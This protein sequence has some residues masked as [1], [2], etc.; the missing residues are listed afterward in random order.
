[1]KHYI[2]ILT[3]L[4]LF[5]C[6]SDDN[7]TNIENDDLLGTWKVFELL[8][9]QGD[10]S[11]T[12]QSVTYN[13]TIKFLSNGIVE[14]SGSL[15]FMGTENNPSSGT[16]ELDSESE[17]IEGTIKSSDC[18][19]SSPSSIVFYKIESS[20]LILRYNCNEGCAEKFVKIE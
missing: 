11:G 16:F 10:G 4:L 6:A 17:Y 19:S 20:N 8:S 7:E 15:C 13:R 2:L 14:S 18:N 5:N 3:A 12:F 9:D 1:M